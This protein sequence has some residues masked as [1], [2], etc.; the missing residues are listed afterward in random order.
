MWEGVIA[1]TEVN[2]QMGKHGRGCGGRGGAGGCVCV[3]C[4][5]AN[6]ENLLGFS[7]RAFR[8][9]DLGVATRPRQASHE[10]MPKSIHIGFSRTLHV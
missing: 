2:D 1:V 7:V 4:S 3:A 6:G 5:R 10:T 8:V 9:Q